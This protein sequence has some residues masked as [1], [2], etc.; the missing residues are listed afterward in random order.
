[1]GVIVKNA[2]PRAPVKTEWR[3][4][5]TYDAAP[6]PPP[7]LPLSVRFKLAKEI[8]KAWAEYIEMTTGP[9]DAE[10]FW[11]YLTRRAA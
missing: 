3:N 2:P 9:V 1:M 10:K 7:P 4:G 8:N 5:S 11:D 6:P